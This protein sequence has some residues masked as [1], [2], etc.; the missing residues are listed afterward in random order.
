MRLEMHNR[1]TTVHTPEGINPY[2]PLQRKK[3]DTFSGLHHVWVPISRSLTAQEVAQEG[4][5]IEQDAKYRL[6][7]MGGVFVFTHPAKA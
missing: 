3:G 4:E 7:G 5:G 6:F 2:I 1:G